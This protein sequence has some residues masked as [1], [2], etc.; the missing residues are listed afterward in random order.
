MGYRYGSNLPHSKP[1]GI[2]NR[3]RAG[4]PRNLFSITGMIKMRFSSP[5]LRYRLW[6]SMQPPIHCVYGILSRG[7]TPLEPEAMNTQRHIVLRLR[8]RNKVPD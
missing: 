5:N 1:I 7:V 6:G 3:L 4:R 2:E 8:F